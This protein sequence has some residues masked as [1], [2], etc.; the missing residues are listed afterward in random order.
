MSKVSLASDILT[1][2]VEEVIVREDLERML[3]GGRKLRIKL[4]IDATSPDLHIGHAVPLWKIR[5]LQDAGHKAVIILGEFT[6]RI[7]D[8]TG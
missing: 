8:P 3:A 6:T 1:R 7:G 2:G 5:A 4:G